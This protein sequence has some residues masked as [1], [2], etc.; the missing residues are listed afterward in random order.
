MNLTIPDIKCSITLERLTS[1]GSLLNRSKIIDC[2]LSLCRNDNH[3]CVLLLKDCKQDQILK[4]FTMNKNKGNYQLNTKFVSEGKCSIMLHD[5]NIRLFISNCP[6]NDLSMFL[7]GFALKCNN[8]NQIQ[9]KCQLFSDE[10]SP[11]TINKMKQA[12]YSTMEKIS[13]LT[14]NDL[15]KAIS[16][17]D[18]KN[19]LLNKQK[20]LSTS[21]PLSTKKNIQ[22]RKLETSKF[23]IKLI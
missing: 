16:F 4:N 17:R 8:I 13:P 7:K 6:S 19:E 18:R 14:N 11:K 12:R 10:N 15:L 9:S 1:S 22:K 21:S 2:L 5:Y 23:F 20:S 3:D